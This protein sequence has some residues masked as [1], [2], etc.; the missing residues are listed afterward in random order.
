[1]E[2]NH[3][4]LKKFDLIKIVLQSIFVGIIWGIIVSIGQMF[5]PDTLEYLAN[6][7]CFFVL[8]PFVASTKSRSIKIAVLTCTLCLLSSVFAYYVWECFFVTGYIPFDKLSILMAIGGGPVFGASAFWS[9]QEKTF[10]CL[11]SVGNTIIPATFL[12]EALYQCLN[13]KDYLW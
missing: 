5:L 4:M 2:N 10:S 7:N 8:I 6:S 3:Q 13:Y 11:R 12:A 9:R 1:M